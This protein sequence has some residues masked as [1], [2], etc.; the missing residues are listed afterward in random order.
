M[1]NNNQLKIALTYIVIVFL[2]I[3]ILI[4]PIFRIAFKDS[5]KNSSKDTAKTITK[6][7]LHCTRKETIDAMS[8]N[9]Q[10]FNTYNE[11][12]LEK[13]IIR[14]NRTGTL[15]ETSSNNII[16]QEIA[17]LSTSTSFNQ[18]TTADGIK[19]EIK[20]SVL[21]SNISDTIIEPYTKNITSEQAL[22]TSN[23]YTCEVNEIKQ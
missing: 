2:V 4:P 3:L 21:K 12:T 9:I 1:E 6:T 5:D 22:L 8:Y 19:F 14:Y 7:V 23:N 13:V 16:E 20:S 18:A 11:N 15:N 10:V 17:T